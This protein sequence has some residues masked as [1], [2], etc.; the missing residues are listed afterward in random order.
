MEKRW[1]EIFPNRKFGSRYMDAQVVEAN[2][3]NNNIVK[4]FIF[5]GAVA[6]MLS[7]TGLFTLVS[8]NIIKKMKEIGVRKVLGASISNISRVINTEF[9]IIIIVS[10]IL[11]SLGGAWMSEMLM[12]SIW[13]YYQKATLTTMSIASVILLL[14]SAFTVLGKTFNTA[15]MNPVNV[16]RDE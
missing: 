13:N 1:K 15:R 6:M 12:G 14:A 3:V 16:L 2:N 7:V 5:L 9:A 8:L 11:G 4:M 10:C